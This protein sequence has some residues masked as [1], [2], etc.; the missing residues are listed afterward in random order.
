MSLLHEFKS[1]TEP[2]RLEKLFP[3]SKEAQPT[4]LEIGCGDGGFL[5]E[6]ATR[7]PEKNFLGVERLLGR[8]RKLDKK[9]SRANLTNLR[10][11]RF[12]ARYLL[13]YLLPAAAF[14][15]VHI[16]FPDPWPKD[17]HAR[18]RLIDEKFPELV[19]RILAPNGSVHLRTDDP[20]Y[21]V[22]MQESFAPAK[23]FSSTETPKELAALTTEFERQ[24]N[25]EGK[26]TLRVSY[27]SIS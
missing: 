17:K 27:H 9:G 11:L 10:L 7:H 21:F 15:A 1:V 5:L 4:E 22:Q 3:A 26:P 14:E 6:W 19:R 12:E 24:W 23:D 25:E 13:Q 2:L 18:H 16:Y 8:I 20:E